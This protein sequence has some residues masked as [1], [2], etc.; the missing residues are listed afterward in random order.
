[1][2]IYTRT[3]DRGETGLYGGRRVQK[4]ALR[5]ETYGTVDECNA[6]IGLA[7]SLCGNAEMQGWL[8]GLQRELFDL[9]ADLATPEDSPGRARVKAVDAAQVERLE[10]LI[11]HVTAELPPLEKFILPGGSPAAS[12]MHLARAVARRAE[13]AVVKLGREEP[14]NPQ[15]QVYLN[16]LSD[17]LFTL[18]RLANHRAGQPEPTW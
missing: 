18:A 8:Q 7:I 13:R 16:R 2:K 5:V 1:M 4:D 6:A 12:A 10:S 15:C 3:G 11:D 9:G 14:V 17:L